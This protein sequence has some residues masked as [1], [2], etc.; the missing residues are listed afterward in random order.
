MSISY[1]ELKNN[2]LSEDDLRGVIHG[3]DCNTTESGW[4]I[5]KYVV[6]SGDT[7][8]DLSVRFSVPRSLILRLNALSQASTIQR[9][10]VLLLPELC[11]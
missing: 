8:D 7:I 10:Q 2:I 11:V 3:S 5:V 6:G 1:D 4:T 9:G